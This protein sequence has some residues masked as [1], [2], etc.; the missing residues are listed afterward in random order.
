MKKRLDQLNTLFV[1]GLF[2]SFIAIIVCVVLQILSRYIF[3]QP[4]TWTEEISLFA[5][6]WFTF[7]GS[8]VCSWEN[9]HLEV[10]FFYNRMGKGVKKAADVSILLLVSTLSIFMVWDATVAMK[11]QAGITSVAL[12]LPVPWYTLAIFL[13]FTGITVFTLYHLVRKIS[14]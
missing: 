5:F 10:D 1:A 12:R 4:L 2:I 9:S 3:N 13:G 7:T 14:S 8:A 6:C 11:A